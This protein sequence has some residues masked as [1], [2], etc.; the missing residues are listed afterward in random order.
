MR[1]FLCATALVIL[2]SCS[3]CVA[4]TKAAFTMN[5]TVE[6]DRHPLDGLQLGLRLEWIR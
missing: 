4:T 2:S 3:G 1:Y 6:L 5:K